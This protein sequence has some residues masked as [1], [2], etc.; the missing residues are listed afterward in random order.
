MDSLPKESRFTLAIKAFKNNLKL[1]L[2]CAVTIYNV[3]LMTLS[4]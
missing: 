3:P 2:R 1:T 4:A